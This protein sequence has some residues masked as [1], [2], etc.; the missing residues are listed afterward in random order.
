ML[1]LRFYQEALLLKLI[2]ILKT[3]FVITG[4]SK[5]QL[6]KAITPQCWIDTSPP[7]VS[8]KFYNTQW[9]FRESENDCEKNIQYHFT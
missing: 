2:L 5:W 8:F 3:S 1:G 9:L 7:P 6:G 4:N